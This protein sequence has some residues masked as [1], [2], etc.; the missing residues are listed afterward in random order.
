MK[1]TLILAALV[2]AALTLVPAA[3]AER[4]DDRGG[5]LGVGGVQ[6]AGTATR[7]DDRAG[8]R[9]PALAIVAQETALRPDDRPGI[10]G[11][12]PAP[13]VIAPQAPSG[14][15]WG[16]AGIGAL[17]AFGICLLVFAGAQLV[18]RERGRHAAV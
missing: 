5:V 3:L 6:A 16:S 12:G 18:V 2:T 17:G 13:V 9:G 10:R 1:A 11:P 7:P 4:P 14:F 8:V 15:D